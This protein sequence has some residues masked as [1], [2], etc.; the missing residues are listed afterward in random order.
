M[1]LNI[2]AVTSFTVLDPG[3]T[4]SIQGPKSLSEVGWGAFSD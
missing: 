1:R 2:S 4:T 3:R